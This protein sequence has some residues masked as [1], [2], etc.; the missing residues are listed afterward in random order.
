[1]PEQIHEIYPEKQTNLFV[2]T[3]KLEISQWKSICYLGGTAALLT[4][5]TALIEMLI[6]FLP[7]GYT[8][9]DTVTGW[10]ELLKNNSFLGLR[11]L[12]LLNI[13]M[14]AFSIPLV[15]SLY[16]THRKINQPFAFLAMILSFIGVA[17]FYATNRAFPILDLSVRYATATSSAERNILE[18]AGQA[19]L[20]VGQSHTPGTFLA[21]FFSEI[22]G[23]VMAVVMLRGRL[24]N[25]AAALA[26]LIGYT[27]LLV[28]EVLS[29]F[30]PASHNAIL[31]LAM[32]GGVT[33][34]T[35]YTLAGLRLFQLGKMEWEGGQ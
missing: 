2:A 22:A 35:W 6:T 32:I 12:G 8:S 31:I 17:V 28:F 18:A 5:I 10:L 23:I 19:M 1:M 21:F 27:F 15:F 13:V 20:S 33:N 9:A 30:D 26:G 29:S 11:N 16:W 3:N 4:V 7:G 14:T 24:F 25:R 34:L